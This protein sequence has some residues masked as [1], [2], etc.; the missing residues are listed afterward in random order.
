MASTLDDLRSAIA[1]PLPTEECAVGPLT[2][3][4]G[5]ARIDTVIDLQKQ[6]KARAQMANAKPIK[7]GDAKLR[8]TEEFAAAALTLMYGVYEP[9]LTFE[10]CCGLLVCK[11]AS[12]VG[13][14]ARRIGELSGFSL[15]EEVEQA[16][17]ALQSDPPASGS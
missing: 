8:I 2:F 7:F 15:E 3:V 11:Y 14:M 12:E 1:E 10:D 9:E 16:K 5:P 6:V 4:I 17:A 13:E